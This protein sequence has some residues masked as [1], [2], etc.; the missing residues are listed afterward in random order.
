MSQNSTAA[1]TVLLDELVERVAR[2]LLELQAQT[3]SD[4]PSGPE[5]SPWMGISQAAAY[6]D[7]PK[8]RLYKLTA[9]GAIPHYKQDGRLAFH[10]TELDRWLRTHAQ[11][12]ST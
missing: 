11:G 4:D 6:L 7:W 2:R 10:R 9:S 8:Q 3:A 1:I 12:P 5:R